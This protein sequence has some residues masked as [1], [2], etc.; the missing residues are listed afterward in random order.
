MC[1]FASLGQCER[2]EFLVDILSHLVDG[3]WLWLSFSPMEVSIILDA[4]ISCLVTPSSCYLQFVYCRLGLQPVQFF[5]VVTLWGHQKYE[6]GCRYRATCW[7]CSVR[8]S[9][10]PRCLMTC[11][12]SSAPYFAFDL[13]SVPFPCN[14]ICSPALSSMSF[15]ITNDITLNALSFGHVLSTS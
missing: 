6:A 13:H 4:E 1:R 9:A 8:S 14:R 7:N 10:F 5:N 3:S 15:E 12:L 2:L 11:V